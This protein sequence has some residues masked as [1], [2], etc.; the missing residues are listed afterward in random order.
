[1]SIRSFVKFVIN[2][3]RAA[4]CFMLRSDFQDN[5]LS[6]A[7]RVAVIVKKPIDYSSYAHLY[8]PVLRYTRISAMDPLRLKPTNLCP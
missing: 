4:K 5:I 6:L 7:S 8:G 1:M 3:C 2:M